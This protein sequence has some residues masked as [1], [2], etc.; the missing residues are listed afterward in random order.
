MEDKRKKEFAK[1]LARI[2][3]PIECFTNGAAC[4]WCGFIHRTITF[5]ENACDDCRKP[6]LFG[7]PDYYTGD[8]PISHV[9][10]PHREFDELGARA[11]LLPKWEPNDLLK[12]HYH[13]KTEEKTGIYSDK[14]K[15]N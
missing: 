9:P 4:P 5:G 14:Q 3:V 15:P 8:A 6:F 11:D 12:Q 7:Y 1:A 10:F 13:Q 2:P